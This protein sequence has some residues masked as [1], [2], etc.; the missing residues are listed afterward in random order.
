MTAALAA[1]LAALGAVA[2]PAAVLGDAVCKRAEILWPHPL[3]AATCRRV[4]AE[5]AL[6]G[7]AAGLPG[8]LVAALVEAESRYD[9]SAASRCCRGL[10]Q[11]YPPTARAVAAK[12]GIARRYPVAVAAQYLRTLLDRYRGNRGAALTAYNRGPAGYE[13][14]RRMSAYARDVLRRYRRILTSTRA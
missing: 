1:A 11:L 9:A 10:A 3:L 2:A 7:A 4:G 6:A 8:E 12:S 5:A 14:T 13:R